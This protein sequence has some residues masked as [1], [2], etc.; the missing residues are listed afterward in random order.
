MTN[1]EFEPETNDSQKNYLTRVRNIALFTG[2]IA[3]LGGGL[4][5]TVYLAPWY[6][7]HVLKQSGATIGQQREVVLDEQSATIDAVAK[8][9]PAV[10]SIV[11]TKDLPKLERFGSPFEFFFQPAPGGP[12]QKQEVG[13]GS[14]FIITADGMIVTNKHVVEDTKAEYTVVTKD[15]QKYSAKVL[16]TDPFNDVAV[17][18]IDGRNMPTVTLGDSSQLKLGQ[19]VVAIGNALGQFQN[20][21]TTGVVSGTGRNITAGGVFGQTETL[22]EVIQTDAAINPGNSGGPLIDLSG[23]VIGV[24]SAV[25]EQGQLIGFAIPIN[26]VKKAIDDVKQFGKVRRAFLG[27]RYVLVNDDVKEQYNLSVNYGAYLL[28]SDGQP[29]VIPG[30]PAAMSGLSEKDVIL[31]LNGQTI[32]TDHNL[33]DII[34][35]HNPGD[36]VSLKVLRQGRERLVSVTLGEA[37]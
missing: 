34:K 31:E 9:N 1:M 22:S 7:I 27:I 36:R 6:Q 4:V 15:G 10:V 2:L 5:G 37:Q 35:S 12:T 8:V 13:A 29:A 23:Q 17:V 21:V 25:S 26:Q 11:I 19:R 20:S 33:A 16:A 24:N 32:D 28:G 18:K 3:G 14:G 30:G